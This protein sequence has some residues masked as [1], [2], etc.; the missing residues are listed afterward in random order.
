MKCSGAAGWGDLLEGDGELAALADF[1][2]DFEGGVVF[3][4]GV[5]D[6]GEAEAGAAALTAAA[7]VDAV[8]A[9]GKVGDVLGF[10]AGAVVFDGEVQRRQ[11]KDVAV[12]L[13]LEADFDFAAGGGVAHGVEDEVAQGV[14]EVGVD[15]VYPEVGGDVGAD[16]VFACGKGFAVFG[17]QLGQ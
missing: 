14:V 4:E 1:A 7:F 15:A 2:V 11:H 16:G 6:D 13:G 9:F 10:D 12:G 5:F 3:G 8:E 17:Q